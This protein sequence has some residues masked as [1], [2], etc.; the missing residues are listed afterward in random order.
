[1]LDVS[2][3]FDIVQEHGDVHGLLIYH[4]RH[5]DIYKPKISSSLELRKGLEYQLHLQEHGTFVLFHF[6]LKIL[7]SLDN[8][9]V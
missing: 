5:D 8:W 6:P 1:M 3:C 9:M 7:Q 2:Y 4:L